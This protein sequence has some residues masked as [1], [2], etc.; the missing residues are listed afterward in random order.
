M[1]APTRSPARASLSRR[2]A[3]STL[4][5]TVGADDDDLEP[6]HDRAGR[7]RAVG[8]RR[9]QADR[10]AVVASRAVIG[11]D[12]QQ[13]GELAL[14]AGVGLDADGVVAG[15]LGQPVLEL[16]DQL[17]ETGRVVVRRERMEVGELGPGDR[18]H[19]R[20]GVELHRAG[21]ERDHGAVEG[22]V[23]IGEAAQVAQHLVLG[24][25]AV[26][27]RLAEDPVGASRRAARRGNRRRQPATVD[28]R[29]RRA[30]R[31]HVEGRRLVEGEPD[32][33]RRRCAGSRARIPTGGDA[34]RRRRPRPP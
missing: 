6:G 30:P 21:A 33:V 15:D 17:A 1:I 2:S 9:D 8:A 25:V 13:P 18:L 12:R 24:A 20:G 3:R 29:T 14:A 32:G 27:H 23:A 5:S 28:A 34:P 31:H 4:P 10:A 16:G 19:L 22:E 26:E 7:V 11:A